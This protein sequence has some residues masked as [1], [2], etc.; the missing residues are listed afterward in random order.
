MAKQS[1]GHDGYRGGQAGKRKPATRYSGVESEFVNLELSKEQ[2]TAMRL[3]RNDFEEVMAAWAE[4]LEEGY[5]V[6]TKYDDYSTAYAAFVIPGE[7]S[8]NSGYILTGRGGDPY[9][10]V[11]EA[12]YKHKFL[13]PGGWA[14]YP[15]RERQIDD[16]DF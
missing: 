11:C 7:G 3:W 13:L 1:D 4:L 8:D 12:L 14:S 9:R 6:N 5:R 16:A 15:K 10:A 2:T